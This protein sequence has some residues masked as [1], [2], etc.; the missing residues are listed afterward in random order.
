ML[1]GYDVVCKPG[2]LFFLPSEDEWYKAAYYKGGGTNAG[3]WDY[4]TQSDTAPTAELPVGTDMV[5]GSANY[6]Y[7]YTYLDTTYYTTE[8]G[9]YSENL[10]RALTARLTKAATCGSGMS[11]PAATLVARG[12][13]RTTTTPALCTP[14]GAPTPT[15]PGSR[16]TIWGSESQVSPSPVALRCWL[17]SP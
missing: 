10:P 2:A 3:Y 7:D 17:G 11:S 9:A 8:V 14:R 1:L 12:A 13:A 15:T 5:N 4:P 6:Y 16:T